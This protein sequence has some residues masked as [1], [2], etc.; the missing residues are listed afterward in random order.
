MNKIHDIMLGLSSLS[1]YRGVLK[2]SVIKSYIKLISSLNLAPE[3]FLSSYGEFFNLLAKR[4]IADN[5]AKYITETVLFDDNVFSL[6]CAGNKK[7][8]ISERVLSAVKNDLNIIYGFSQ[9]TSEDI[10]NEYKYKD[11]IAGIISSLPRWD[12]GEPVIE[13]KN[14]ADL[15]SLSDFYKSNGFGIFARYKAFIW[16]DGDIKPVGHPDKIKID[17]FIGYERPR[18]QVLENTKAFLSGK[19]C[20]NCL[21]Y[22]DMGTGKSSTVKAI[23]NMFRK[24]GLR[25]VEMPKERLMDFP[26]LIDKI[27]LN[28]MKFIIFVDDLSFQHQDKNYTSLKAVLEGGLAAKPDNALI[29]ATSNRR[30]IIKESWADRD[31]DDINRRDNMQESLSLSDRFGLSVYFSN[32]DK[33]EYLKIVKSLSKRAGIKLEE[34][35]LSTLAERFALRKGGRSPRCAKQFVESLGGEK[36]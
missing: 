14:G 25:I 31:T 26:L 15:N 11:D 8:A 24:D 23:G 12:T 20:N 7:D 27:A 18:N 10:F 9:I 4:N 19:P 2:R 13:F 33:Y 22:G 21:L 34:D 36:L 28:P 6:A 16:R 32:P 1:V 5:L 17:S 30:H 35:E 29:Y 3:Q